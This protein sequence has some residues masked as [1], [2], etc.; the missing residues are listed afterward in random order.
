MSLKSTSLIGRC[1]SMGRRLASFSGPAASPTISTRK[2]TA[3][4]A[5]AIS[6]TPFITSKTPASVEITA[7]GTATRLTCNEADRE[8]ALGR[9]MGHEGSAS[10]VA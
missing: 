8:R 10:Q 9:G 5:G 3:A 6:A 7:S 4:P 2:G 1:T